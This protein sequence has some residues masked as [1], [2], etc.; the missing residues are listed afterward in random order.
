MILI[1][2][3]FFY[4]IIYILFVSK[5]IQRKKIHVKSTTVE[6][7]KF[8]GANFPGMRVFMLVRGDVIFLMGRISVSVR[9]K[10]LKKFVF[11]VDVNSLG[12]GTHEYYEN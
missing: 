5:T 8:V 4:S 11:V 12:R 1:D 3:K 6:S 7:F 9:I 2:V 10:T